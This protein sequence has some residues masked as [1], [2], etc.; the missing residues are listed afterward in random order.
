[1]IVGALLVLFAFGQTVQEQ[2]SEVPDSVV[3]RGKKTWLQIAGQEY[4]DRYVT[5]HDARPDFTGDFRKPPESFNTYWIIRYPVVG[6]R[7]TVRLVVRLDGTPEFSRVLPPFIGSPENCAVGIDS[8][9]AIAIAESTLATRFTSSAFAEFEF[10]TSLQRFL[11]SVSAELVSDPGW[12]SRGY[13]MLNASD[14]AV[15]FINTISDGRGLER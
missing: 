11:W 4:F 12:L 15:I 13:I 7:C 2:W 9:R 3:A 8:L 5:F 14:G 6:A 10:N 1:M